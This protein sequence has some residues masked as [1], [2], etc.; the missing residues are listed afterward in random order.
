MTLSTFKLKVA[1]FTAVGLVLL[2]ATMFGLRLSESEMTLLAG[3]L[4]FGGVAA[5]RIQRRRERRQLDLMRDSAL[6]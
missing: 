4:V 6:W 1:F 3:L 5:V 2:L